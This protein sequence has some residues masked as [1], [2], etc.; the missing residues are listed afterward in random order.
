MNIDEI[1][2]A[3]KRDKESSGLEFFYVSDIE[4]ILGRESTLIAK[5]R[6]L[7]KDK[8]GLVEAMKTAMRRFELLSAH[9]DT[10][11]NGVIPSSGYKDIDIALKQHGG[12]QS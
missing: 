4:R 8:A 5:A 2:R 11:R 12:E 10:M 7:E 3:H 1:E 9:D 6:E